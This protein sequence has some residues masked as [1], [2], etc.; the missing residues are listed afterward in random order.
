MPKTNHQI[1]E[2]ESQQEY[3]RHDRIFKVPPQKSAE[4]ISGESVKL[5]SDPG[6]HKTECAERRGQLRARYGFSF[7][8]YVHCLAMRPTYAEREYC[9]KPNS[10]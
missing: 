6:K 8:S 10:V 4:R 5:T 3:E 7:S 2:A 9:W 1:P